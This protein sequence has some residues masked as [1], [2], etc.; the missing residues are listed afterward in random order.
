MESF[1]IGIHTYLS[2][3][4]FIFLLTTVLYLFWLIY[5]VK[6]IVYRRKLLRSNLQRN[7][8]ENN[9]TSYNNKTLL[10]RNSFLLAIFIVEWLSGVFCM[11]LIVYSY[12]QIEREC[13]GR[14]SSRSDL[15]DLSNISDFSCFLRNDNIQRI[16]PG[17]VSSLFLL[18]CSCVILDAVLIIS[19]CKYLTARY[20]RL[21]W[22]KSNTIPYFIFFFVLII[23]IL[24]LL[25][26]VCQLLLFIEC[27]FWIFEV[28]LLG[29]MFKAFRK[30]IM[31]MNWTNTDLSIAQNRPNL[32]RKFTLMKNTFRKLAILVWIGIFLM[33]FYHFIH[34]GVLCTKV[35]LNFINN[36]EKL[37][38]CEMHSQYIPLPVILVTFLLSVISL[39]AAYLILLLPLY[40]SSFYIV[41]V[42]IWR[43][44]RGKSGFKTHYSYK[45]L[46]IPLIN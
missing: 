32:L 46:E 3:I 45:D 6:R 38:F 19:L 8:T 42:I 11:I 41:C 14:N 7:E 24:N 13:V 9:L 37:S 25:K 34:I 5:L 33:V 35:V 36:P 4:G 29:L 20:A 23:V 40:I 22:I 39:S 2:V 30:L 18:A 16:K 27:I 43:C 26:F 10:V 17:L 28:I 44:A 21:S 12:L 1:S 31:V 15:L